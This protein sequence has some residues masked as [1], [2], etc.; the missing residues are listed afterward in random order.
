M[1]E[2]L[3]LGHRQA[4]IETGLHGESGPFILQPLDRR[5]RFSNLKPDPIGVRRP[6]LLQGQLVEPSFN[7]LSQVLAYALFAPL[8][9][10]REV[11][12]VESAPGRVR[13]R[14]R[15][16]PLSAQ[17]EQRGAESNQG[18]QG[19]GECDQRALNEG[20]QGG[21]RGGGHGHPGDEPWQLPR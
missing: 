10:R 7:H 12:F 20:G 16:G 6:F 18:H 2:A 19:P 17:H 21:N 14:G 15:R 3:E 1:D 9:R 4:G 13:G 8:R 11:R 5:V